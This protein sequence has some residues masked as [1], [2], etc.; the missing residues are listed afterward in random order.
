MYP[1]PLGGVIKEFN[2]RKCPVCDFELCMY[3]VGQP[4]RSFPLC[5]Y[6][7]NNPRPEWG[8]MPG[9]DKLPDDVDDREDEIKERKI[10][11]IAGRTMTL[12][13]PHPDGHPLIEA[14]TVAQDPEGNGV[15]TVDAKFGPKWKLCGTREPTIIH[16][17]QVVEKIIVLDKCDEDTKSHMIKVEFKDGC[18]FAPNGEASYS[19]CFDKDEVLQKNTHTFYGN[20]RTRSK[21]G[22]G[23]RGGRGRGRGRGGRGRGRRG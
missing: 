11:S 15:F 7:F 19:T 18:S 6:C 8:E 5:P 1:L 16:M 17:P 10:R 2:S 13:C 4:P 22:R 20:E 23:G 21:G 14:L 9:E 3:Q 12:Q